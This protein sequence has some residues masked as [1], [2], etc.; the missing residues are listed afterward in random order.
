[1]K[2]RYLL[3]EETPGGWQHG[4]A[5]EA[6]SAEQAIRVFGEANG[7]GIYAATPERSWT[8]RVVKIETKKTVKLGGAS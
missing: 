3:F 2:T 1:M 4:G 7:E 5:I 8:Q 6:A